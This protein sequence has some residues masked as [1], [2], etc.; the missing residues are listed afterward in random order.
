MVTILATKNSSNL[1]SEI[2]S[3]LQNGLFQGHKSLKNI[4]VIIHKLSKTKRNLS[5]ESIVNKIPLLTGIVMVKR[6]LKQQYIY[7]DNTDWVSF[8]CRLTMGCPPDNSD[9]RFTSPEKRRRLDQENMK[10]E[11]RH[12]VPYISHMGIIRDRIRHSFTL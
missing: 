7:V 8:Q 10:R 9:K 11:G 6:C 4:L 3:H 5:Q 2:H 12:T 1:R